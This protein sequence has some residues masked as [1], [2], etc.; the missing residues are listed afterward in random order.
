M[1]RPSMV[2]ILLAA[3]LTGCA[4]GPNYHRPLVDVPAA[5]RGQ[6]STQQASLAD[7]PWWDLFKDK[8]LNS[9]IQTALTNN[10]DLRIAVTH[11]ERARDAAIL[12]RSA[13]FPGVAYQAEA[14]RGKN[15]IFGNP[16]SSETPTGNAFL[17]LFNLVWEIDLWGRVRRLNESARAQFLASEQARRGVTLS[18][19]SSVAQAYFE[20]LE[21]DQQIEIAKRMTN[22]FSESLFIFSERL[23]GGVASK[24]ETSRAEAA[25]A[26]IAAVV[27]E[28]ERQIAIKENQI[29]ILLGR[30]PGPIPRK[31][32]LLQQ[33]SP[34]EV[35]AGL[36]SALIE[37]RPDIFEAELLVRS[38]NAQIGVAIG[39]FL[40][41]VG[42][43]A[44]YGSVSTEL[45]SLASGI[46]RTWGVDANITGPLYQGGRIYS[47]YRQVKAAWEEAKLTYQQTALNAFQE[48]ANA[49]VSHQKLEEERIQQERAVQ[50]YQEAVKVS[51]ERYIAG[52]AGYFEVL[53]VQQ[54]LF[55]AEN[56]LAHTQL[57]QLLAIVQIYKALGGGWQPTPEP[58][59]QTPLEET[60]QGKN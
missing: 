50:A 9:L 40:P 3:L 5:F 29:C 35:P 42:L 18:L 43:T 44:L 27:P 45:S 25:L 2:F 57:N 48:V 59:A 15:S 60:T 31:A 56:T 12:A 30:N 13:L 7:L 36:P 54:Q 47:Q 14:A 51:T 52:N 1:T 20:L 58:S 8:T 22:S 38:A 4:V 16:N 41:R 17:G 46:A 37:R 34:P 23:K 10:Y 28:L 53:E 19:V 55:P 11:V 21:L 6:D 39:D 24:L 49:L 33:V 26:S 32:N